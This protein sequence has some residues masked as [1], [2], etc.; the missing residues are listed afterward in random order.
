MVSAAQTGEDRTQEIR[1]DWRRRGQAPGLQT[2]SGWSGPRAPARGGAGWQ[3]SWRCGRAAGPGVNQR[4]RGD[5]PA[6][7]SEIATSCGA[8]VYEE[9]GAAGPQVQ[10]PEELGSRSLTWRPTGAE[11]EITVWR[12]PRSTIE[13]RNCSP[14]RTEEYFDEIYALIAPRVRPITPTYQHTAG[15]WAADVRTRQVCTGGG[16][17]RAPP[18]YISSIIDWPTVHP[19]LPPYEGAPGTRRPRPWLCP[20]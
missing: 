19:C 18:R 10:R 13:S 17:P 11:A 2:P 9:C 3:P 20:L 15:S 7:R 14:R 1:A 5:A 6:D 16:T 8:V 12:R 4:A